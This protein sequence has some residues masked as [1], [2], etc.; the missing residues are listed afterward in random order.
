MIYYIVLIGIFLTIIFLWKK[1]TTKDFFI[2]IL[3][4]IIF[5]LFTMT[6][7]DEGYLKN[8]IEAIEAEKANHCLTRLGIVVTTEKQPIDSVTFF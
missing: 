6:T 1:I 5:L 7:F 2:L 4:G 8:R 3:C